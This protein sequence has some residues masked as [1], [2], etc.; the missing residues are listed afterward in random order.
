[1][2]QKKRGLGRGLSELLGDVVAEPTATEKPQDVFTLPIEF[3]QRGKYQP[4]KD[5][6]PEKLKELSDSISAQG[7]IQ[8]I[9]VRKI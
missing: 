3:L 5:M 4:R 9:V 2:I 7:I 1:M 8:P 6:D